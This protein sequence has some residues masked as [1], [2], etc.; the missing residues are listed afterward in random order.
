MNYSDMKGSDGVYSP[1]PLAI[2]ES[3]EEKD[4][5]TIIL[6][7][8]FGPE[9]EANCRTL[10]S[11]VE[12]D[13]HATRMTAFGEWRTGETPVRVWAVDSTIGQMGALIGHSDDFIGYDSACQ[14]IAAAQGIPTVTVFAG[15]NNARFIRRWSACGEGPASIVHVNTL[16]DAGGL[17]HVEIARRVLARRRAGTEATS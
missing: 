7:K 12:A 6:D 14:H 3:T 13:G 1:D 15:T 17:D 2:Q 4:G 11:Q 8:G 5:T 16:S 9:E 10:L